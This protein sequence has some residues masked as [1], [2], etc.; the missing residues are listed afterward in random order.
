MKEY[1]HIYII[2]CNFFGKEPNG[3]DG[4][5]WELVQLEL[6]YKTFHH[7]VGSKAVCLVPGGQEG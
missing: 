4:C 3:T 7:T 6:P 5:R 2:T 1:A